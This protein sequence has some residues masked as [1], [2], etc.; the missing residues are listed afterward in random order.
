ME[1]RNRI[2]VLAVPVIVVLLGLVVYQYG[3]EKVHTEMASIREMQIS[4]TKTLE[5]YIAVIS[6]KLFL[7]GRLGSLKEKR[8]ADVSKTITGETSSLAANTLEDIVK[9]IIT[10]R[11]GSISSERVEKPEDYGKFKTVNVSMDI[12][13]PDTRA[14]SDVIYGIETRTPYIIIK[15]LDVRVRNFREPRDLMVKLRVAALTEGK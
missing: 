5:K 14:L 6:E 11:G 15:E 4:K 12:V 7:E 1:K 13:L 9:G 10:G 2:I 3:Y 8:K